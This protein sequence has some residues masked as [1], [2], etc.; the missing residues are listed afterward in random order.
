MKKILTI[1]F[2]NYSHRK[3][4]FLLLGVFVLVRTLFIFFMP[5]TFSSDVFGWMQVI[6]VLNNGKNPYAE[7]TYL[8]WPPLWMQILFVISKL[9]IFLHVSPI[10][11]L[12][13]FLIVT[14]G[15][16]ILLTYGILKHFFNYQKLISIILIGLILNPISIFLTCQHCNFDILVAFWILLFSWMILDFHATHSSV[17]W[18]MACFFLGM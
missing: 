14:E 16:V 15:V 12:Q 18:L 9:S 17:S 13:F 5:Y 8:N 1:S 2:R 7:T 3:S 11:C 4:F 10:R 6:G